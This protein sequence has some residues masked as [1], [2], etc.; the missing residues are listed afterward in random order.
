MAEGHNKDWYEVTLREG[1]TLATWPRDG[2]QARSFVKCSAV[3]TK[4]SIFEDVISPATSPVI[5]ENTS[6]VSADNSEGSAVCTI[7]FRDTDYAMPI[8]TSG[9]PS[10]N[11]MSSLELDGMVATRSTSNQLQQKHILDDS[12]QQE[13][14]N[15]ESPT[16]LEVGMQITEPENRSLP[17]T[18]E[19]HVW[20]ADKFRRCPTRRNTGYRI[21]TVVHEN[22]Y[23]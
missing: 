14:P 1:I 9:S 20:F 5:C 3:I 10:P 11:A 15:K 16:S 13:Q 19:S 4:P 2:T 21:D 6:T 7:I 12:E 8:N 17:Q 22:H 18:E 23:G